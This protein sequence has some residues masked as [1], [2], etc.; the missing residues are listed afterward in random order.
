[1]SDIAAATRPESSAPKSGEPNLPIIAM[2]GT[3]N[4]NGAILSGLIASPKA[5][6]EPIRVTTRSAASA[7]KFANEPR[8]IATSSESD[9]DA[10]RDAVRGAGLVIVGVKPAM[11]V[12]LLDEIADALTPGTVVASVAAGVETATMA[13]HLPEHVRIVRTMPNTP[14]AVGLGATGI[15]AG[16]G[17]DDE[18]MALVRA[19]FET[20]GVVVEVPESQIPAVGAASGSGPAHVY[21]LIETMTKAVEATGLS[22]EMAEDLILESFRGAAEM[23]AADRESGPVDLRRRVTSPNGTT[24]RSIAVMQDAGFERIFTDA[25]K[26]NIARSDEL[27][28]GK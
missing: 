8:V 21:Y 2:L 27:A 13:S 6:A 23:I 18:A 16:R 24:E 15:A 28:A 22:H 17:A 7:E 12:D 4:M 19:V 10:N 11:V 3:G 20:V 14:A 26:A 1:M 25:L 9:A 5:P